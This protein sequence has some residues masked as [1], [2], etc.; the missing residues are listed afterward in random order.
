LLWGL[1]GRSISP[2]LLVL[3]IWLETYGKIVF[4]G[5][6]LSRQPDRLVARHKLKVIWQGFDLLFYVSIGITRR[7]RCI[8]KGKIESVRMR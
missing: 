2:P 5:E 6:L 4:Q 8:S 3:T 1:V 7:I